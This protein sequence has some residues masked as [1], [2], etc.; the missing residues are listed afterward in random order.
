MNKQ[1]GVTLV[2]LLIVVVII[3]I[4]A[5]IAYPSYQEQ[6]RKT[7]RSD[8]AGALVGLANS[9][10]RFFTV[11]SSYIGAA[12]GGVANGA[13]AIFA[14]SCPIDGGTPTY[15]LT[16]QAP[17]PS[18]FTVQAAPVG[19]QTGDKCGNLTYTNTGLKGINGEAAGV[20]A[21]DCW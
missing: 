10:E 12:A 11:N 4:I 1:Q 9:M 2:E 18:T 17:G 19:A 7:R 3:G 20:V 8:C 6:V 16:I 5:S 15:N 13:P 21:Q 14:A